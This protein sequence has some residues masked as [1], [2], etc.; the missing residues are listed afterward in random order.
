MFAARMESLSP[1]SR[2]FYDAQMHGSRVHRVYP[3]VRTKTTII[4]NVRTPDSSSI[5]L[6]RTIALFTIFL[7][8]VRRLRTPGKR[9]VE[10]RECRSTADLTRGTG[11]LKWWAPLR[12]SPAIVLPLSTRVSPRLK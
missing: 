5:P 9:H 11:V 7:V 1:P 10:Y 6:H 8:H 12:R 3:N 4:S 2:T